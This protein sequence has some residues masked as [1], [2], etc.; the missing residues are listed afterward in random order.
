LSTLTDC[1]HAPSDFNP[2][3]DPIRFVT[4][5]MVAAAPRDL[6][7]DQSLLALFQPRASRKGDLLHDEYHAFTEAFE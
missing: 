5:G 4:S 1:R 7:Y 6:F 3:I 2:D